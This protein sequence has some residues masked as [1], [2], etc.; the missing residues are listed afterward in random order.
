MISPLLTG[1]GIAIG[2]NLFV[3]IFAFRNQTDK[4]T[5]I[6]YA[7]TFALL[8]GFFWYSA[9]GANDAYKLSLMFM[10]VIWAIRLG[11]YLLFRVMIK[12]KDDRFDEWRNDIKRYLRF[13][14]LQGCSVW[15]LS[16]PFI[17]GLTKS[18]EEIEL[19]QN[20][21]IVM[22][23]MALWMVGFF[24]EAMADRQKFKFRLNPANDGKFMNKGLFS[25]VRF[26]NYTGEI[27]VW[28]GIFLTVVPL[29]KGLEWLSIISP[30]WIAFLLIGLSGIPF[31]ERSN[32]KRYGDQKEFQDYK[33]N[34]KRLLPYIY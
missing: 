11:S 16:I 21:K 29:L 34:T 2:L 23:G 6:T 28:L 22:F 5:D 1:L 19:I 18:T 32:K 33:Q 10:V 13:W 25:I 24:I 27:L 8:A 20:N 12:G 26:P 14:V 9:D 17:I 30:I 15:I 31:L 7:I 4:L 3:F